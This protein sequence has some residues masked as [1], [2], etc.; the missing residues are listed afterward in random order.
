MARLFY[1]KQPPFLFDIKIFIWPARNLN[2]MEHIWDIFGEDVKLSFIPSRGRN[3]LIK[4]K[5]FI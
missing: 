5:K 4:L 2:P 1:A 3:T